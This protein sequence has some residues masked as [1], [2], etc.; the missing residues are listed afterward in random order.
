MKRRPFN[1]PT[2]KLLTPEQVAK[3]VVQLAHECKLEPKYWPLLFREL[4]YGPL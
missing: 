3:D 2:N 4:F 1:H